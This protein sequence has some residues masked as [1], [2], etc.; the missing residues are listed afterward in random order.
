[1]LNYEPAVNVQ[2]STF[3]VREAMTLVSSDNPCSFQ[4]MVDRP[5]SNPGD[6]SKTER[7]HDQSVISLFSQKFQ[8]GI[9]VGFQVTS[10]G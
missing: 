5:F 6:C 3:V 1:M 7:Y 2:D 10:P 8:V 9:S 4:G